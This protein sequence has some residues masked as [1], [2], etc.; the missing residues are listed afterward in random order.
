MSGIAELRRELDAASGLRVKSEYRSQLEVLQQQFGHI[1]AI[2]LVGLDRIDRF[3]CFAFALGVW[4]QDAYVQRV[5][6]DGNSAV[7][8]SN[9][10]QQMIGAGEF[11]DVAPS[12][13]K[14]GDV[15]LYFHR[16]RLT[17]AGVIASA[18]D[19]LVVH[20]LWN[21]RAQ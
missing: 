1:V 20:C 7:L 10:V 15:V 2:L 3:N 4:N 6:R 14:P 21:A 5:D 11:L 17:H 18:G 19:Q 12:A 13:A 9:T 16:E 8:D